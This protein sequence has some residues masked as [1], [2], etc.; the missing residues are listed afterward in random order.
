MYLYINNNK[1]K[2][3]ISRQNKLLFNFRKVQL[4]KSTFRKSNFYLFQGI[5]FMFLFLGKYNFIVY[6]YYYK[7]MS[8]TGF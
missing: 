7:R 8:Y 1:K 5:L 2:K 4:V 3:K 6:H